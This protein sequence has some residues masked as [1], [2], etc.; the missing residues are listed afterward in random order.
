MDFSGV[1]AALTTPFAAD[2][3][4][5]IADLKQNIQRY[6]ATGLAGYTVQ[7]GPPTVM[8]QG[9]A[10]TAPGTAPVRYGRVVGGRCTCPGCPGAAA[11]A[12]YCRCC[13]QVLR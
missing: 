6:N 2:D 9:G 1:F 4:V 12:Q 11:A 3:A 8:Y 5:A 7:G 10:P 13:G